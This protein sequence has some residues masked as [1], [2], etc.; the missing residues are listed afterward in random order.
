M[1]LLITCALIVLATVVYFAP[2]MIALR[3]MKQEAAR[4]L[5]FNL[6]LGWTLTGWFGAL[7]YATRSRGTDVRTAENAARERRWMR[8]QRSRS[9]E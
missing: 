3:R 5:L 1:H 8:Q 7:S 4:L 2:T 9:H 6:F